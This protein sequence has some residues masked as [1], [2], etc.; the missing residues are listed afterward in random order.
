MKSSYI[1]L[2]SLIFPIMAGAVSTPP[3]DVTF[4]K[5]FY[6]YKISSNGNWVGSRTEYVS[7]YN[8]ST[9]E[10]KEYPELE[11]SLGLGNCI[12]DQGLV[13]GSTND[14]AVMLKDGEPIY[15]EALNNSYWFCDIQA[16]TPDGSRITGLI[17]N[18]EIS[19]IAIVPFVADLDA[20]GNVTEIVIPDFPKE[21]FFG[22]PPMY[23]KASWISADGKTICGGV[24]DFRGMYEYPIIYK[25]TAAGEWTYLC[26]SKPLF[27]PDDIYLPPNPDVEEPP[28]PEPEDYM[29][30]LKL[31]AYQA[32]YQNWLN[33]GAVGDGPDIYQYMTEEQAAQY[34]EAARFYNTWFYSVDEARQEYYRIYAQV[35]AKSPIFSDNDV[36]LNPTGAFMMTHA[37]RQEGNEDRGQIYRFEC[38]GSGYVEYD[39]GTGEDSSMYP[40]QIL[41]NGLSLITTRWSYVTPVKTYVISPGSTEMK[42]VMDF[43]K[44]DYNDI[45]TWVETNFSNGTGTVVFSEDMSVMASGMNALSLP[46]FNATDDPAYPLSFIVKNLKLSKIE[47]ISYD[48]DNGRIKVYNLQGVELLD[49]KNEE[50]VKA[51]PA[52]IYIINGKKIK[53]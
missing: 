30:G 25:E 14:H 48:L 22:S 43:L 15:P 31:S 21:D 46:D 5:D 13:V 51:L 49:T 19:Q 29:S 3:S 26:P 2:A 50:A 28:Y 37:W 4:K 18:P 1:A 12:S 23:V 36:A 35:V 10:L 42:P 6:F 52:G 7:I 41:S 45:Y 32:A 39:L 8:V 47:K 27:N 40:N 11:M 33:S 44:Q 20:N 24:T 17:N 16:I 38:D 34:N 53:I 9:G